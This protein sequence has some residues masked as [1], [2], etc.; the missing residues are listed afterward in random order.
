MSQFCPDLPTA[1]DLQ[2]L[3][4]ARDASGFL[5][6]PFT[7]LTP[8]HPS[9]TDSNL[10]ALAESVALESESE[11]LEPDSLLGGSSPFV[12][13]DC[14]TRGDTGSPQA[15]PHKRILRSIS[16]VNSSFAR[17]GGPACRRAGV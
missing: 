2:T 16:S 12:P 9:M 1:P 8:L 5:S 15:S 6:V 3:T 13:F 11:T 10:A 4:L 14:K 17:S 7:P